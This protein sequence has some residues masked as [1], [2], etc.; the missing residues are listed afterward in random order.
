MFNAKNMTF[1]TVSFE[2][3]AKLKHD[4]SKQN[5]TFLELFIVE[6]PHSRSGICEKV[7]SQTNGDLGNVAECLPCT[8]PPHIQK[9]ARRCSSR[10]WRRLRGRAR[11]RGAKRL[12]KKMHSL[13]WVLFSGE[14]HSRAQSKRMCRPSTIPN[15][16]RL[17]SYPY[18]VAYL[19]QNDESHITKLWRD[20]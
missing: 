3:V 5:T 11:E 15:T 1:V 13:K 19:G 7:V 9:R 14:R 6:I 18:R 20:I 12:R 2:R 16:T 4:S 10:G 8:A 17:D